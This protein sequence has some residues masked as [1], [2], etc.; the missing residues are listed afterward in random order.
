MSV[1]PK[2]RLKNILEPLK[3]ELNSSSKMQP[4]INRH[5]DS[6][7]LAFSYGYSWQEVFEFLFKKNQKTSFRY[8][9]IMLVRARKNKKIITQEKQNEQLNVKNQGHKVEKKPNPFEKLRRQI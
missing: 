3:E 6:I 8:L 5:L 1:E 9:N 2:K 4:C 7:E